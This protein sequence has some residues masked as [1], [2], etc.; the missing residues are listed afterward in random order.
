MIAALS[1]PQRAGRKGIAM[2][3]R[4]FA[5]QSWV[6]VV[7]LVIA[8]LLIRVLGV[9]AQGPEPTREPSCAVTVM[10]VQAVNGVFWLRVLAVLVVVIAIALVIAMIWLRPR[11]G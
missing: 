2:T 8:I 4:R 7:L 1:A 5:R 9:E 10:N 6:L 11:R 3:S